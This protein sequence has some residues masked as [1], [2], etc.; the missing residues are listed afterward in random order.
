MVLEG[1]R[2][3]E[4]AMWVAG[5]AAGGLLADWG[6]DVIKVEAPAGDPQRKIFGSLGLA[7][8]PGVPPFEL[9]NR[10]KRS[11][12]LDLHTDDGRAAMDALLAS[13]DV[14]LTN[15]RPDAL[16]RFGLG[17]LEVRARFPRLVY[18][19]VTGYGLEGPDANRPGY[20]IGAFYA[21][22]GIA[23]SLVPPGDIPPP[24]RSGLGDHV[25]G[26]T[27]TTGILAALL[28]RERT[29]EGSL[30]ATSLLRTGIYALGWDIGIQLRFGKRE[31]TR[32]RSKSRAPLVSCYLAAD[33][34]AFWLLGLEADRHWPGLLA[35]CDRTDLLTDER[36]ATAKVRLAN[37]PALVEV[38]DE[39]FAT[40]PFDEWTAAFD[41]HDV[42]WAP[43]SSIVDVIADPQAHAA[44]AFVDMTPRDGEAPY[45][46]V[47]SPLDFEGWDRAP[48]PVPTVGEHTAEVL[49]EL[50]IEA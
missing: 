2:V 23:H 18:A 28:K 27:M 37:A 47:A 38:L 34:R 21:R 17:H 16:T 49:G 19:S 1:Y 11:V 6:A 45:R 41:A 42:W 46:A 48:G 25:T 12:V 5:P 8:Q 30:V 22:T 4:L 9:D 43:V 15:L 10:G 35:A 14:F 31:S 50:G 44:G 29:G 13:A 7:D 36:F 33:K 20:D 40:R 24:L 26:I 3:V 39:I 32:P